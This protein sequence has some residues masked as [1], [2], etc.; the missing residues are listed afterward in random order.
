MYGRRRSTRLQ[1]H[2]DCYNVGRPTPCSGDCQNGYCTQAMSAKTCGDAWVTGGHTLTATCP[3]I[4]DSWKSWTEIMASPTIISNNILTVDSDEAWFAGLMELYLYSP[5]A[6]SSNVTTAADGDVTVTLPPSLQVLVDANL[7]EYKSFTCSRNLPKCEN[8][9]AAPSMCMARCAIMSDRIA[10]FSD[11]C[12]RLLELAEVANL[13][14]TETCDFNATTDDDGGTCPDDCD[15]TAPQCLDANGMPGCSLVV[16]NAT[17]A[18]VVCTF[19]PPSCNGFI[20]P[21]DAGFDCFTLATLEK[22]SGGCDE[23]WCHTRALGSGIRGQGW[24]RNCTN[25][26]T[27][28]TPIFQTTSADCPNGIDSYTGRC[29]YSYSGGSRGGGGFWALY[30]LYIIFAWPITGLSYMSCRNQEDNNKEEDCPMMLFGVMSTCFCCGPCVWGMLCTGSEPLFKRVHKPEMPMG[31]VPNP[32]AMGGVMPMQGGMMPVQQGMYPMQPGMA[33][34]MP[35]Q[36]QMAPPA[37]AVA[38]A[39]PMAPQQ[40]A[41]PQVVTIT[42]PQGMSAGMQMQVDP[43]GPEGPLPPMVVTIPE[44]LMGG[45]QMQ[46]QIPP[47]QPAPVAT[48]TAMPA[49]MP[50][51]TAAA[52]AA[53]P[54]AM[55]AATATAPVAVAVATA[56]VS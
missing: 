43:D 30:A 47:P 53:I 24:E 1:A 26:C 11:E 44:G 31:T 9:M 35:M 29:Y 50:V 13:A 41:A 36:Q 54:V 18:D 40:M 4:D 10:A 52:P 25:L 19:V 6:N 46:I 48:A 27:G 20:E 42:V 2:M 28:K 15:Y 8:D 56:V 55:A 12:G 49:A 5:T 33:M 16:N 39:V 32:A 21:D 14:A 17:C 23:P 7:P 37:M 45:C 3:L 34:A 51:A 22:A 38:C